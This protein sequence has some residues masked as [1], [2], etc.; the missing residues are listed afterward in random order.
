VNDYKTVLADLSTKRARLDAESAQLVTAIGAMRKIVG[1]TAPSDRDEYHAVL[2]DLEAKLARLDADRAELATAVDAIT[3]IVRMPTRPMPPRSTPAHPSY[4]STAELDSPTELAAPTEEATDVSEIDHSSPA[5]S[6]FVRAAAVLATTRSAISDRARTSEWRPMVA[7]WFAKLRI[8]AR[9]VARRTQRLTVRQWGPAVAI[10][11]VALLVA[12]LSTRGGAVAP[13]PT[14]PTD[15]LAGSFV[16][17]GASG[18]NPQMTALITRFT[19][20]HPT[21]TFKLNDI[22]TETSIVN[23]STGDVDFGYI[24][25][26]PLTTEAKVALTPI[27]FG[28]GVMF[29][30]PANP[31]TNLTKDQVAK[32]YAGQITDWSE[33]GSPAGP[34]KAFSREMTSST[35]ASI[36][37]YV[38]GLTAPTYPAN[39]QEIPSSADLAKAVAAFR[40][41]IGYITLSSKN[42]KDQTIKLIGMDGI[43]PTLAMLNSG[44]WKMAKPSY[45]TTNADPAKVKP[46]I[47][48]LIDFIKSPEGQKIIAGE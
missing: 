16:A 24:G 43:Q 35:R 29:V 2:V 46:A 32:I 42:L 45:L 9:D 30:N 36:E 39:I 8:A 26:D 6:V 37:S 13:T 4:D 20:L 34:I 14:T 11:V 21:S 23:V 1:I 22:D 5:A 40:G 38:Y 28:G 41:A 19:Q 17:A 25:R 18:A 31:I 15:P 3:K 48:A 27:G 7:I 47:K 10:L 44:G 33:V 12:G